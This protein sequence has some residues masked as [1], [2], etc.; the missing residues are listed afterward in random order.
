MFSRLQHV[1]RGPV[2]TLIARGMAKD[3]RFGAD[4]RLPLLAGV[5]KLADAVAVTMGPKGRTVLIEQPYGGPKVTKDGVTVAKAI[6]LEDQYENIGARLVQDVANNT[7]DHA[8]DGT[9]TATVLARAIATEGFNAVAAGLN[10]GELRDGIDKA[11]KV[12][13]E[14]IKDQSKPVTTNDEIRQ[15]A[16]ISANG[17]GDIG[18]LIA[19]GFDK[20]GKDV[21]M[22]VK[23]GQTTEDVLEVT[24]GMKFDRGYIS[25]FFINNQKGRN[26]HYED[27]VVLLC[28]TKI[29]NIQSM[30]PVLEMVMQTKKPLLIIAEDIDAE[31]LSTLVLNRIRGGLQICAV[32]A[33]GFG[34]NRK[35]TLQDMAVLTGGY[36]FGADGSDDKLEDAKPE[37]LGRVG[38]FT[39]TKEDTL[40]LNGAGEK[41]AIEG[42]TEE[43][44]MLIE[45]T[46][47]DYEKEKLSERLAR[48]AGGVA[49]L[50][51]GGA[52]DIEVGEK[53]DRITDAL[54]ATRA[55]IAEGIIPGGGTA[56]LRASAH[57]GA[58]DSGSFDEQKGIEIIQRAITAPIRQI[59][60]NGAY[61]GAVIIETVLANDAPGFGFD[62]REGKYCDLVEE[63]IIDPALVVRS[64]LQDAVGVSSLLTT[65]DCV[66]SDIPPP[67]GAA[68]QMPGGMG[69]MGGMGM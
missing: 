35:N 4:A 14:S 60:A 18:E 27:A 62:A 49:V 13:L 5:N 23:D 20:V 33:P 46:S 15:V 63:G 69:G 12:V 1:T 68:P 34:D 64:A 26:V 22:T 47:S 66:I 30:V 10:P 55:A 61:E 2:R 53:K 24:E 42:R 67:P 54:N 48:L 3:I 31:A 7:N 40:L 51:V 28:Q 6:E 11:V 37:H 8:G 16:T 41:A 19:A 57:L 58:L 25:P 59:A 38:E 32:K 21:V 45:D 43:I 65:L 29:S 39:A 17:A 36:V 50:K 44:K 56:L 52:S 9:T